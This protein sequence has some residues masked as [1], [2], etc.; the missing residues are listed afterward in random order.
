MQSTNYHLEYSSVPFAAT[1]GTERWN[2]RVVLQGLFNTT[3]GCTY[4][5]VSIALLTG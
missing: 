3:G 1:T 4:Q 5:S 2:I